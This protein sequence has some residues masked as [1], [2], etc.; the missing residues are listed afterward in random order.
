MTPQSFSDNTMRI[1]TFDNLL[2]KFVGRRTNPWFMSRSN[3]YKLNIP[4]FIMTDGALPPSFLCSEIVRALRRLKS[5]V[6]ASALSLKDSCSSAHNAGQRIKNK[7]DNSSLF[8][9]WFIKVIYVPRVLPKRSRC[10]RL[11][12]RKPFSLQR[13]TNIS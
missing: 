4:L 7:K 1:I 8:S 13:S 11:H 3:K 5:G 10:K 12:I 6:K 2:N 9:F